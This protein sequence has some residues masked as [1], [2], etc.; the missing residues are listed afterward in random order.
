MQKF[1]AYIA[2]DDTDEIGYFTSTGE[3]CEE[4]REH[5]ERYYTKATPITRHQLFLHEDIPY[6]S[7][8]SSMCFSAYL[9]EDEIEDIKM[10]VIDYVMTKSADS[11][12]PGIC[13]G[14]EKDILDKEKLISYGLDA[15]K[16][17]V[18]KESAYKIAKE[19]NLFLTELKNRGD[20]VIGALAGVA[21]RLC[22]NDGRIKGK[23]TLDKKSVSV[24]EILDLGLF[25]EVR[26]IGGEIADKN[27]MVIVKE[28]LKGVYLEHKSVLLVE[29]YGGF[30]K[31]LV[32]ENLLEY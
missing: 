1:K 30:Y 17:V 32:K 11:S 20:G 24:K 19:Q 31:P 8:N 18:T 25:D 3:I 29:E 28:Y 6:T 23:M 9:S 16:K 10:F 22:G 5:V 15:K 12:A 7:H 2:I 13:I 4:I 21:L 14:F 26:L 27:S